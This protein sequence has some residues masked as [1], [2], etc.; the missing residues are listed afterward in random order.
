MTREQCR[1]VY[2]RLQVTARATGKC[3]KCIRR[4]AVEGT[5]LCERCGKSTAAYRREMER[6]K[7]KREELS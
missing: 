7:K 1:E 5:Y 2:L 3:E 6:R 4:I